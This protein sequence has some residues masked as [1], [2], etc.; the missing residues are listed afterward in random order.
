MNKKAIVKLKC[1]IN[2]HLKGEHKMNGYNIIRI[3]N[4]DYKIIIFSNTYESQLF[5]LEGIIKEFQYQKVNNCK[6]LFDNILIAGNTSERYI[7]AIFDGEK[8]INSSFKYVKIDKKS[9]IRK[10]STDYMRSN[11]S[12]LNNSILMLIK[13]IIKSIHL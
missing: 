5:H 7:E 8:F 4:E 1:K 9:D 13:K 2:Q 11:I 12:I 10:V 6:I 3:N